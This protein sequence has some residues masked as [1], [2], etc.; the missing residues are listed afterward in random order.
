MRSFWVMFSDGTFA[1]TVVKYVYVSNGKNTKRR[2]G[3]TI[4]MRM[5]MYTFTMLDLNQFNL[6]IAVGIYHP[7]NKVFRFGQQKCFRCYYLLHFTTLL[8][9]FLDKIVSVTIRTW[10]DYRRITRRKW[11]FNCLNANDIDTTTI[12]IGNKVRKI[13]KV[14]ST[15]SCTLLANG[16]MEQLNLSWVGLW[17]FD[18]CSQSKNTSSAFC[19]IRKYTFTRW[20]FAIEKLNVLMLW[21]Y[22]YE[23]HKFFFELEVYVDGP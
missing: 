6:T 5:T 8:H 10:K 22:S 14:P 9:S 20:L 1:A 17:L 16:I 15:S 7:A 4:P 3:P 23:L 19:V 2:Q 12:F 21:D 18:I 11:N 13:F